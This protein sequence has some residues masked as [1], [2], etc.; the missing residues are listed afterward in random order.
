MADSHNS[1]THSH[2]SHTHSH[3]HACMLAK[4]HM[5]VL[6]EANQMLASA[7]ECARTHMHTHVRAL[8]LSNVYV[9]HHTESYLHARVCTRVSVLVLSQSERLGVRCR[10]LL[11]LLELS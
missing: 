1:H 11:N 7:L 3:R 4:S 10:R 6:S 5:S 2:N 8:S 9:V